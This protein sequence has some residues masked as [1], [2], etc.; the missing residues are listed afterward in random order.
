MLPSGSKEESKIP[1]TAEEISGSGLDTP[2]NR[3][4][5]IILCDEDLLVS[6]L[7]EHR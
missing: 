6:G 4:A 2:F 1:V 3:I 7:K 5:L